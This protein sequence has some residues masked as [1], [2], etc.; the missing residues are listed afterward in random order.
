[1][2]RIIVFSYTKGWNDEI[3]EEMEFDVDASEEEIEQAFEDWVWEHIG[4]MVHW[5]DKES[6]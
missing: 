3:K 2:S 5:Y 1:M 6:E 4:D